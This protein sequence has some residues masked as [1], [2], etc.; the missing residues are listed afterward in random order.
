MVV[1]TGGKYG[2]IAV[3]LDPHRKFGAEQAQ[4]L[5]AHMPAEQAQAGDADFRLRC[6]CENGAVG[7]AHDDVANTHGRAAIRGA[8]DLRA[9]DFYPLAA[10]GVFLDGSDPPRASTVAPNRCV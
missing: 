1:G 6:A 2:D 8:F 7:I 10:A 3:P 9:A 5:G 4:T